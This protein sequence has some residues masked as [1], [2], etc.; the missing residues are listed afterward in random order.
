MGVAKARG[1]SKL[2]TPSD[3]AAAAVSVAASADV[4]NPQPV[5][6]P[7]DSHRR[8]SS[9]VALPHPQAAPPHTPP[10]PYRSLAIS[11]FR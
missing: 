9:P 3:V 2:V 4:P 7:P 8:C 1:K 5:H 6:A 10:D 11:F